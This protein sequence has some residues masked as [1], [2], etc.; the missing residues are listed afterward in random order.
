MEHTG[1]SLNRTWL[2]SAASSSY[3]GC[4]KDS[5]GGPMIHVRWPLFIL[6][7]VSIDCR[8]YDLGADVPKLLEF[9]LDGACDNLDATESRRGPMS[10]G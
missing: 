5:H 4:R 2:L 8:E 3:Y 7:L 6:C 9:F 1:G 10:W